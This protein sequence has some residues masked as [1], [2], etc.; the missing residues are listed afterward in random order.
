MTITHSY[1]GIITSCVWLQW[2]CD[3]NAPYNSEHAKDKITW[4]K[5]CKY[6]HQSQSMWG[7]I[8]ERK[9]LANW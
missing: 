8:I 6:T 4:C 1:Y 3:V 5:R 2:Q 7:V 9:G